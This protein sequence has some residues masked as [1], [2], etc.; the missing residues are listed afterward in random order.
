MKS[1][2]IRPA[3]A[4]TLALGLAAC[5]GGSDKAEFTVAGT[6]GGLVYPDL[7]LINGGTRI[8][9]APPAKAGDPVTFAFPNKLEY[10]DEYHVLIDRQPQHQTCE[11]PGTFT[12]DLINKDTAGRLARINVIVNCFINDFA[13]G[14]KISGLTVDGLQLANGSTT[15]ILTL[16]KNATTF[17]YAMPLEVPYNVS[18]GVTVVKQPDGLVCTVSNPTGVMGDAPVTN[19]NVNCVPRT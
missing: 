15:G 13:I 18:Y 19:I 11:F 10:G 14:G 16:T 17:D 5:G 9:V 7:V 4:L 1:S 6:I 12:N 3:L 8:N 2:L